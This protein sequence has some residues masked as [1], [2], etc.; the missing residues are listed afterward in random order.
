MRLVLDD[1]RNL[2][3]LSANK[4]ET[5]AL[6]K[7]KQRRLFVFLI[8]LA[9]LAAISCYVA[10]DDSEGYPALLHQTKEVAPTHFEEWYYDPSYPVPQHWTFRSDADS[11]YGFLKVV[12]SDTP[13]WDGNI[14]YYNSRHGFYVKH[15]K[16]MGFNQRGE[17]MLG[18]HDNEFYNSDTTLVVATSAIFYDV[19]LV[20]IPQY[21]DTL[22]AYEKNFLNKMGEHT[23]KNISTDTWVSEGRIDHSDKENPP[24]DRFL[25]KWLLKKDIS[26]RD[27]QMSL[28]IYFHDSLEYRL[29]ELEEIIAQFPDRP[30]MKRI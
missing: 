2:E 6:M 15:P 8:A 18:V 5:F 19:V 27:C 17:N 9:V 13:G 1:V 24:A 3:T 7:K 26:R 21:A 25:R 10:H 4:F 22:I 29:P 11:K 12:S 28:T 16:G 20:D 30:D 23:F 14:S